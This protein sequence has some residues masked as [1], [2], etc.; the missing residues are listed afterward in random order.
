MFT[1]SKNE[2]EIISLLWK[3]NKPLSRTEIIELSPDKTWKPSS[4]HILLNSL[5]E[6]EAIQVD[7]FV[8]TGKNYGRTYSAALTQEEYATMQ[9]TQNMPSN[10]N[11]NEN[12]ADFIAALIQ[13]EDIDKEVLN[14]VQEAIDRKKESINK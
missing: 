9:F 10:T 1:L 6:K 12:L 7:G 4:I 11:Q 8:R 14:K 5:L 2:F 3:E 13:K